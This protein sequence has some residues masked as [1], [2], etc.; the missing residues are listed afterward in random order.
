M[1][2]SEPAGYSSLVIMV[3]EYDSAWPRRFEVLRQEYAE[4]LASASVPVAAIEH[5]GSTS[6][7]G[8]AA[9]PNLCRS[10]LRRNMDL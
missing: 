10:G 6:V 9:K 3:I 7:P 8:L 5:V 4:A 1:R 2:V